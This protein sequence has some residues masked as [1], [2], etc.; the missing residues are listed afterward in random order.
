LTRNKCSTNSNP[1]YALTT[2]KLP[3]SSTQILNAPLN[4]TSTVSTNVH[5][6]STATTSTNI[7][8]TLNQNSTTSAA[9]TN[10]LNPA[11]AAT[12]KTSPTQPQA[13]LQTMPTAFKPTATPETVKH[14]SPPTPPPIPTVQHQ[15]LLTAVKPTATTSTPAIKIQKVSKALT[16]DSASIPAVTIYSA[17]TAV[18]KVKLYICLLVPHAHVTFCSVMSRMYINAYNLIKYKLML[19][20]LICTCILTLILHSLKTPH[21]VSLN[22]LEPLIPKAESA[23]LQRSFMLKVL[24]IPTLT[25][26]DTLAISSTS[27]PF[28]NYEKCCQDQP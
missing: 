17:I 15:Q 21:C 25:L 6:Y 18:T 3:T 7:A 27:G 16:K 12:A 26:L 14:Q 11:T 5:S 1:V 24:E 8:S 19:T 23:Q 13:L 9:E 2:A 22:T 20:F 10:I 4:Q 28:S